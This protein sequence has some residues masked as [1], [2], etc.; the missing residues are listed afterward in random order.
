M[1]QIINKQILAHLVKLSKIDI[2]EIK[3]RKNFS[4]FGK[5]FRTF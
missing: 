4:G 1:K 3:R 2:K 5:N